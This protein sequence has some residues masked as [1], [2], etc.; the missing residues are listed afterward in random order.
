MEV[1]RLTIVASTTHSRW[2]LTPDSDAMRWDLRLV[3][4]T[5]GEQLCFPLYEDEMAALQLAL[6][7]IIPGGRLT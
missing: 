4:D 3:D 7:I 1:D 6:S 5:L 2:T